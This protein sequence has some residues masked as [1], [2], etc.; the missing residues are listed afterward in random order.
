MTTSSKYREAVEA[1]G[2]RF[3]PLLGAADF[4]GDDVPA[5]LPG[6]PLD[7]AGPGAAGLRAAAPCSSIRC[8]ISTVRSSGCPRG[9]GGRRGAGRAAA[10]R[11][12][13]SGRGRRASGAERAAAGRG[14]RSSRVVPLTISSEDTA[15]F[16]LGLPPDSSPEGREAQPGGEHD[17]AGDGV[18]GDAGQHLVKGARLVR[19]VTEPVPFDP[20]RACRAYRTGS[21]SCRSRDWTT[22]AA[23]C[24]TPIRYV[25]AL[26]AGSGQKAGLP[27]WWDEVVSARRVV[28]VSQGTAA[29]VDFTELVQPTLDALADL[30]VLVVATLGREAVLDRVPA[31]ARGRVRPLRR[32]A[33]AHRRVGEQRR[34]RR[35]AAGARPRCARWCWRDRPRTRPR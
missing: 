20:G 32:T 17:G 7:T 9:G 22:R 34:V 25:G 24:R 29:N 18:R 11:R 31:N 21:C 1:V 16:G 28:V 33:A 4:D 6:D 8:R 27:E 30:D 5:L 14:G 15:P 12:A 2:A 13:S 26:P 19:A 35:G 3:A 23:I 10:R